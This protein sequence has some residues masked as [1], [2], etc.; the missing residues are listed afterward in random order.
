MRDCVQGAI[1]PGRR[2]GKDSKL[3]NLKVIISRS[4]HCG[5]VVTNLSIDKVTGS[6]PGTAQLVK[7]REL[8]CM[9]FADRAR[10]WRCYGCDAGLQ[11]QLEFN[12]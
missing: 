12:P 2:T 4:S 5:S 7:N 8:R 6:I 11:L 10:T 9:Q 3:F 1:K